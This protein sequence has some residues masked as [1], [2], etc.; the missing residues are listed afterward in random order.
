MGQFINAVGNKE[1]KEGTILLIEDY[2][3]F[4]RDN[5]LEALDK[6]SYLLKHGIELV[7]VR[8]NL[9]YTYESIKK[10]TNDL[11]ATIC[12]MSAAHDESARKSHHLKKF[13]KG[14]RKDSTK[15]GKK[16]QDEFAETQN[17]PEKYP[18]LF[19]SNAPNWLKK[20]EVDGK[21]YYEEIPERTEIIRYIFQLAEFGIDNRGLGTTAITNRLNREGVERFTKEN[22]A[23][24][25]EEENKGLGTSAIANILNKEGKKPFKGEKRN[26][27]KDFNESYIFRLLKDR[28]LLGEF[29]PHINPYDKELERRI[30]I[31]EGDPIQHYFPQIITKNTFKNVQSKIESRKLYSGGQQSKIFSNLF[32]K[33]AKCAHCGNSMTIVTKKGSKAEGGRSSYLQCRVGSKKEKTVKC[34]NRAVR[35]FDTLEKSIIHS[36]V[37]LDLSQLFNVAGNNNKFEINQLRNKIQSVRDEITFVEK[38]LNTATHAYF[39]NP[40]DVS[41]QIARKECMAEQEKLEMELENLNQELANTTL[42]G[43]SSLFFSNLK[44]VIDSFDKE[45][46]DETCEKRRAIN[47]QLA[48]LVQYIAVDGNAKNGAK[49]AWVVF[50]L[51]IIK[52]KIAKSLEKGCEWLRTK[53][54]NNELVQFSNTVSEEEFSAL[55]FFPAH[56]KIKLDRFK[57]SDPT[58]DALLT[59]RESFQ[60]APK[61]LIRINNKLNNAINRGWKHL[62]R[63]EYK[64]LDDDAYNTL[65]QEILPTMDN[66]LIAELEQKHKQTV[67]LEE[68]IE[69]ENEISQ[70][71]Q[72]LYGTK[73]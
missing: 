49:Y 31:P 12:H 55:G 21:K 72:E 15:K 16:R 32:T 47:M 8:G 17:L 63:K 67:N 41:I 45:S 61:E 48:D 36:L 62:R 57:D 64:V 30:R 9:R 70:K 37:E 23:D 65:F 34:G 29:Q 6:F 18:V 52:A 13:W 60:I 66:K 3:R 19:P 46:R 1:Y 43:D 59:M 35:Y 14:V 22:Q 56:I 69:W 7:F 28:R 54:S 42:N 44:T 73:E 26:S 11:F 5:V 50:D 53:L 27:S 25:D 38:K 4:S 40:K 58:K 33:I 71:A 68:Q 2:S 51:N 24:S 10:N 39:E 20:V